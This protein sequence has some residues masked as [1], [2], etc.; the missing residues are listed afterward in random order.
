MTFWQNIV[1]TNT[2]TKTYTI[3]EKEAKIKTKNSLKLYLSV[4]DH[5]ANFLP[6]GKD[7]RDDNVIRKTE[8]DDRNILPIEL[9]LLKHSNN[10]LLFSHKEARRHSL[11]TE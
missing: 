10:V 1:L 3:T 2:D 4:T 11:C 7:F 9:N 6:Y 8:D 5:F